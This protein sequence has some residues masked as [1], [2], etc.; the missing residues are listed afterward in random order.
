MTISLQTQVKN[1]EYLQAE[2]VRGIPSHCT[3]T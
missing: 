3:Y 2:S 1:Q